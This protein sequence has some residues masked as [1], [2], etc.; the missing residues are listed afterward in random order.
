VSEAIVRPSGRVYRPRKVTAEFTVDGDGIEDGVMVCG[1][2]DIER[3]RQL[4]EDHVTRWDAGMAPADPVTGWWR[5]GY[6]SSRLVWIPDEEKGRA[7]VQF[8]RIEEKTNA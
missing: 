8:T 4:A 6:Q 1:T 2:H 5:L 3:A 7:A